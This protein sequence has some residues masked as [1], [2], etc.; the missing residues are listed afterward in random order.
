MSIWLR[1]TIFQLVTPKH[2]KGRVA[3]VNSMF[4]GSSNE[5]G[6]FESGVTAKIMGLIPSVVFGGCMT[7]LVVLITALLEA[8]KLR[9]LHLSV[10]IANRTSKNKN[11][12]LKLLICI[13]F[14]TGGK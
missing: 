9:K 11:F 12:Y 5:I 4:I 8:P 3:A 6:E 7:L 13:H 14:V 2:M 10:Y 1:T